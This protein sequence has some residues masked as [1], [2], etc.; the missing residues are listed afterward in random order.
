LASTLVRHLPSKW[1]VVGRM[2][3]EKVFI[4]LKILFLN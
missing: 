3:E 2:A 1:V 4:I